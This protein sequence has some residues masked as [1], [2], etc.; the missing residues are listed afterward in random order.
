MR[1]R[2][3]VL[4]VLLVYLLAWSLQGVAIVLTGGQ[5]ESDA[6]VPWLLATMVVPTLVAVGFLI[7]HKPSRAGLLWKPTWAMIPMIVAGVAIPTTTAFFVLAIVQAMGW[8]QSGWFAFAAEGVTISGG[9][10]LLGQGLQGWPLF[11]A[12]IA[13]TGLAFAALSAIPAVGEEFGWRAFLQ[14]HLIDKLGLGRGVVLLG[15]IWSFFH[16]PGLLVG[17]NYP[18]TPVLGAFV[19]FPV[20]LVAVS[21]FMA[22]L[23]LTAR[24]FWPAAIAH[25]AGNSIQEGVISN[26]QMAVPQ[27]YEDLTTMVV[28][29]VIGL[30]CWL[31]LRA[32]VGRL[33]TVHPGART[34]TA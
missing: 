1:K 12:N 28:T 4:Y 10:W 21:V 17:Y 8:G 15:L 2:A 32:G 31:F 18:E 5:L 34:V 24:S 11:A 7:F 19:I 13:A 14:Q 26:L 20:E 9:P 25:G 27:L 22:W 16:L 33:A 6:A 30:M 3:I 23:T 29:V